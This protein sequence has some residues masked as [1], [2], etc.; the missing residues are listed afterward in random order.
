MVFP[1]DCSEARRA[2]GMIGN[3]LQAIPDPAIISIGRKLF[4]FTGNGAIVGMEL[5]C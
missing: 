4:I 3:L 5:F 1:K 2:D